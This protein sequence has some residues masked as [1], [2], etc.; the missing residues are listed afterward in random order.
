MNTDILNMLS[1]LSQAHAQS[2]NENVNDYRTHNNQPCGVVLDNSNDNFD[3][4][5]IGNNKYKLK[6]TPELYTTLYR[7][8]NKFHKPCNPSIY[9]KNISYKD[10]IIN[11]LKKI[12]FIRL[13]KLHPILKDLNEYKIYDC[14]MQ[15]DFEGLA[16]HYGFLTHHLD[17]TNDKNIAMFFATTKYNNGKYEVIKEKQQGVLYKLS[18]LKNNERINIIG[19]QCLNRP[20]KQRGFSIALNEN[21][22]FNDLVDEIEFIEIDERISTYYYNMFNSG[23]L[24]MP[25]DIMSKKAKYILESNVITNDAMNFF[26]KINPSYKTENI[27]TILLK[28]NYTVSNKSITFTRKELRQIS[29]EWFKKGRKDFYSKVYYRGT[30]SP[31]N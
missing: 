5:N 13:L 26:M 10:R 25:E 9:R 11:E 3:A 18:Y 12:E 7:G 27:K 2:N 15:H 19:A 22:N 8:Q 14:T 24:L 31:L 30:A 28:N 20:G 16:Q 4:L 29:K 1:M 23:S 6:P 17:L 21:E